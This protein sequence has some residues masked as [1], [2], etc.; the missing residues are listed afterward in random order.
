MRSFFTLDV[1]EQSGPTLAAA[2]TRTPLR[3]EAPDTRVLGHADR[4]IGRVLRG[5]DVAAH[6]QQMGARD[7]P[8]LVGTDGRRRPLF[9]S[10]EAPA[11][12]T[13]RP[14]S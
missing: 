10:G 13:S 1:R 6:P 7:P 2:G 11:A 12:T 8:R 14:A 9:S 4:A 5:F 3:E